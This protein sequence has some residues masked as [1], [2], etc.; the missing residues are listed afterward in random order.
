MSLPRA[1]RCHDNMEACSG[2]ATNAYTGAY[3]PEVVSGEY[4]SND[5]PLMEMC[6]E[7]QSALV[8]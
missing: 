6:D 1:H 8:L 4:I 5:K 2:S 7:A 3:T